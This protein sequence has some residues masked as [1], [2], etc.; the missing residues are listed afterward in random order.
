VQLDSRE[1]VEGLGPWV[2]RYKRW[3]LS[4]QVEEAELEALR[5]RVGLLLK[6]QGTTERF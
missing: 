4:A 1:L 6:T 3:S 2:H 5:E